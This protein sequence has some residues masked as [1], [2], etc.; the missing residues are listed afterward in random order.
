[1]ASEWKLLGICLGQSWKIVDATDIKQRIDLRENQKKDGLLSLFITGSASTPRPFSPFWKGE[2]PAL[3]ELRTY[4]FTSTW[5]R[6]GCTK[7]I[8]PLIHVDSHVL[9]GYWCFVAFHKFGKSSTPPH[10]V[11][12]SIL[13][14]RIVHG[15]AEFL[16]QGATATT[17]GEPETSPV[18]ADIAH[19]AKGQTEKKTYLKTTNHREK[20]G[21]SILL[22]LSPFSHY[23]LYRLISFAHTRGNPMWDILHFCW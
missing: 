15:Y 21:Y 1:M 17:A 12:A 5:G 4:S 9:I 22:V 23:R 19:I 14:N 16:S 3:S 13:F 18:I 20:K 8:K 6:K 2:P 11:L 7:S 10:P